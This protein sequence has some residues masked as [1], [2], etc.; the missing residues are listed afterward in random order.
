MNKE[1]IAKAVE[2]AVAQRGCFL[3]DVTVSKDNDIEIIIESTRTWRITRS[4]CHRP[5]WTALSRS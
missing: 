1:L 2:A 3:V 4:P 5:A